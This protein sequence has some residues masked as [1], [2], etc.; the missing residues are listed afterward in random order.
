MKTPN[1]LCLSIKGVSKH[2]EGLKAVS[3][4]SF[5][6]PN[7]QVKAIIG[8]NGAGKTTL[9][10]LISGLDKPNKGQIICFGTDI[11]GWPSH[12][13][14][15]N[16]SMARTFQSIRL[17]LNMSVLENVMVG[18]HTQS[19]SGLFSSVLKLP[20]AQRE[21]H[22]ARERALELLEFVGLEDRRFETARNLPYG[23]QRRLEIA[24]AL[25]LKPRILLLDE[26]SAGMNEAETEDLSNTIWQL[27]EVGLSILLIEHRMQFVMELSDEVIVMHF[28]YILAEGI[29]SEV[30]ND[31]RVIKAYLGGNRG[32]SC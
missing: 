6:V 20:W 27:R 17:F 9:F 14:A 23:E 15:K 10:N 31:E 29:P 19:R 1:S 26:P 32:I 3:D 25:A 7:G 13:I 12:R 22:E 21:E 11:T 28:G 24:R 16:M 5:G 18:R 30:Q 8:P 2:F 4:V